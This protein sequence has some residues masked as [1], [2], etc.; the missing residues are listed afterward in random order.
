MPVLKTPRLTL[1][2][3]LLYEG[4]DVSTHLR[5][6]NSPQV[7]QY[8][9]QRHRTHTQESQY[10]YLSSFDQVTSYIWEI[11]VNG[12]PLG[13]ITAHK[14]AP[15]WTAN[16]GILIGNRKDWGQGYGPEAWEAVSDW[17][18]EE[19]VRKIEAG[20]MASNTPM[21]RILQKTGFLLEANIPGH[22]LLN[23]KPEDM[24]CY[25]K[26]R[27]AKVVQIKSGTKHAA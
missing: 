17:L 1:L 13:T 26:T 15:N 25:G 2:V 20:C 23:G 5:W 8:S 11:F 10:E 24:L 21:I 3:P 6:L 27:K 14:D 4:M 12:N 9:E 7:V 18:F 16:M 19:G 22:F